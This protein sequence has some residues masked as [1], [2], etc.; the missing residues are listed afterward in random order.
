MELVSDD[1]FAVLVVAAVAADPVRKLHL[2]TLRARAAGRGVDLVMLAATTMRADSAHLLLRYCHFGCSFFHSTG[3]CHGVR[4]A[5]K[6]PFHKRTLIL[7]KRCAILKGIS[8]KESACKLW[9]FRE[10][11]PHRQ[12]DD[13]IKRPLRALH[14]VRALP[15]DGVGA[16][17]VEGLTTL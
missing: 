14:Q 15:L 13:G 12:P 1:D 17:F 9:V 4:P 6:L 8:A 2:T 10:Q 16:R 5:H 3:L 7:A 11:A